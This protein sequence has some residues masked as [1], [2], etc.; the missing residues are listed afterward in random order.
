MHLNSQRGSILI[1][2]LLFLIFTITISL[3]MYSL[4]FMEYKMGL[5]EHRANQAREL[6]ES[7]AWMALEEINMILRDNY[8]YAEELPATIT[9]GNNWSSVFDEDKIMETSTVICEEQNESSCT[10]CYSTSGNYLG[11]EKTLSVKVLLYF[12]EYYHLQLDTN[13]NLMAVFSYRDYLDRGRFISFNE[14][15]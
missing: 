2:S 11:A 9:L 4:A 10:Y 13:G 5:Y 15:E 8:T 1:Y 14:V 3:T 7:A 6:A 12:D